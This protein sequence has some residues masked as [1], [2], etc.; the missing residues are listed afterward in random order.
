M[1]PAGEPV[2]VIVR[3]AAPAGPKAPESRCRQSGHVPFPS[4][5]SALEA[6]ALDDGWSQVPVP[7][8][9]QQR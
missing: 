8:P 6:H 9:V 3:T 5:Q 2:S 7:K 4:V 1:S